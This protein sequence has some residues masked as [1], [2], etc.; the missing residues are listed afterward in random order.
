MENTPEVK[1]GVT[2]PLEKV[3]CR[4]LRDKQI[5]T[6]IFLAKDKVLLTGKNG[7]SY[8][9]VYLGDKTG[10]ID[11]R[12][13]DNVDLLSELFQ[14]GDVIK[15]KGQ[16]QLFQNRKQII[17]HRLERAQAGEYD[18]ADL[19]STSA[20]SAEEMM[21]E[22]L[23]FAE[24]ME[25]PSIRQLTL[26]VLNDPEIRQRFLTAPAAKSIHHAY[27][28]GLLEH[29]L[30]ICGLM[31]SIH[32][33]YQRQQIELKLDY[34]LFG[35]IFHDIGKLWELQMEESISYTDKGKLLGHMILAVELIEKKA[36]RI[37]G[38]PEET[39]DLLKHIVLSHHGRLEYGSPKVPMFLEA[40]IVAAVDDFDSKINTIAGFVRNE[41]ENGAEKWS[42]FN[43]LFERYFLLKV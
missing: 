5:F 16:V 7:K 36:S 19:V 42:R 1:N 17:V 8:I 12:I 3:F 10:S 6:S 41:R 11:A 21:A 38:F 35:A 30:S 23:K 24:G 37:L 34:L 26:D 9:S 43:T 27:M 39:K 13:W 29:V 15:V 18:M 33:H 14:S 32:A 4:D 22:L 40:F 28:S 25:D 31:Q 20:R 2:S